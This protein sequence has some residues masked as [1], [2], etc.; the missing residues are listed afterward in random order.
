LNSSADSGPPLGV[1]IRL[2]FVGALCAEF[3]T[4]REG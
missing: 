1:V 2:W 3:Q 4:N